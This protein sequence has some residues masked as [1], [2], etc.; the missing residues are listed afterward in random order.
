MAK[1][2]RVQSAHLAVGLSV[3]LLVAQTL[4]VSAQSLLDAAPTV[5]RMVSGESE[6]ILSTRPAP[7]A[8]A[9]VQVNRPVPFEQALPAY[10]L[11]GED[12][13]VRLS[14]NLSP[15]QA[16]SG[17]QL[18]LAYR[19]AVSVLPDSSV[20]AVEING[21]AAGT[22]PIASPN[23]FKTEALKIGADFL[24]PGRN[25][26]LLRARQFHRVD[27]SLEATYELWS[28]L[29]PAASGFIAAKSQG[30]RSFDD[31]LTIARTDAA[32]T[33]IRLILPRTATAEMLND[34]APVLQTLALFLNRDDL[35]V[36][37]G[38]KPGTGP[39][40]DL[41]VS[42][43]KT[44]AQTQNADVPIM[45]YG[46]SV[47]S[48]G[49]A[50]R[51]VV[52]LRGATRAEMSG[53]LL[54]AIRGPLK[55]SLD[56]G[57]FSS[58]SGT[59]LAD[60]SSRYTLADTGYETRVFSGRLS[61]T[62]FNMVMPADFY[63]ADYATIGLKL[64]A[65]T[66][67]GLKH[68]A[69]FLVRVN[70]LV[71]TSYPF[72]NAEGEQFDGK[73]IELPLRAF[74]P[75][76]NKVELLA[77]L[78]VEADET[79]APEAR[80]DT[81][82]RFILL[83]DTEIEIPAL[84]RI[85]RLPDIGAFA[86]TAYPY[87]DGKPFDIIIERPDAQ[88]AG[89]ALTMLSRLALAARNPLSADFHLGAASTPSDRN[90]LVI[91]TQNAFADLGKAGKSGFPLDLLQANAMAAPITDADLMKTA[92]IGDTALAAGVGETG[93]NDSNA[94]LEAFR[95]ST[96]RAEDGLSATSK[97]RSWFAAASGR[98]GNWLN[99]QDGQGSAA[100][101]KEG[102]SL[103]TLTQAPS[104]SGNAV[105]TVV[106]AGSPGDI[107]LGVRR[108]VEPAVWTGLN[109]GSA[110][111]ETASLT[112]NSVPAGSR[113]VAGMTDQSPGNIRRLAAAWFSDNFQFYVLLIV[114]SMGV[115]AVWLGLAI[116]RKGVRSD[117]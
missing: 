68:T 58:R 38:E 94:L 71:V 8:A 76:N 34:A 85:G 35:A 42:T 83:Q 65:A 19:N 41:Y 62:G 105:W 10:R 28:E 54:E 86:G 109:G 87:A 80:D 29:D 84:A 17:G 21:K 60:A 13:V 64:H 25:Q 101:L 47:R 114:A 7:V 61:R 11:S 5:P 40:I 63:P 45:P 49:E 88:S 4:P 14:F 12:D 23:G 46:F 39:G 66:S 111:I 72:R 70:D 75:G 116:P 15:E 95:K 26:V 77:E 69:Q 112:V 56:S 18:A 73:L 43:D 53:Q 107:A 100:T 99:Y 98:F 57:I 37:V 33:D 30:F 31:L 50:G 97:L 92:A 96:T 108:L 22:F 90:A 20:M 36:T 9:A 1:L 27:C 78:P 104:P 16:A 55:E 48:A 110:E 52:G 24:K 102:R 44:R 115:F 51:A 89:A 79:C 93:G 91:T 2:F 67:P 59:I 117:Q 113:F 6:S 106:H 32:V 82:P 103:L 74:R 81:R 3:A